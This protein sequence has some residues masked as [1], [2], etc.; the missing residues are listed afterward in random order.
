MK[1]TVYR[2][3]LHLVKE[4]RAEIKCIVERITEKKNC[5]IFRNSSQNATGYTETTY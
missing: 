1:D 4:L 5:S 2:N 3:N